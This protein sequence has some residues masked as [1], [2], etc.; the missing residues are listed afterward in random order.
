MKTVQP[1]MIHQGSRFFDTPNVVFTGK[2]LQVTTYF[3]Y[4][5]NKAQSM[6]VLSSC[7]FKQI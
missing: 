1:V 7:V 4:L 6:P 3:Q 2:G 5:M